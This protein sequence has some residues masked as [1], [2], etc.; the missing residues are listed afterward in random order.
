MMYALMV[1]LAAPGL[2]AMANTLGINVLERTRELG[3]LRALGSTRRQVKRMILAESLL[4]A[5]LGTSLGVLTGIWFSYLLVKAMN[6][7]GFIFDFYFPVGG[8]LAAIATG[9]LFG[10]IAAYFPARQAANMDIVKALRYE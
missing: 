4:L 3:M 8:A 6:A 2:L 7:A 5:C 9:L 1:V 10:V